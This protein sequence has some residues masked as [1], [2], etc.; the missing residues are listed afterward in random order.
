MER[1][2]GLL[3]QIK[4]FFLGLP[5][6]RRVTFAALTAGIL[7]GT[8][9]LAWWVQQPQYR[10]L[11][12]GLGAADA[13]A[14]IEYLK[15]EKIPYRVSDNGGNIEVAAGRLY[16]TRMALAGRGI[17][18]GGGVGFEIFDKQTL[19]MTDFVQR[20]NYQ[21]ALQGELARSI[22]ELDTVE[23][24]RVH[25]AM[26]ERSLF[27]A[28][29][30]RPSASVVLKLR[31]GRTL[32]PEQI[33]GVVHLVA[34]S[35]EGLRPNDVTVVDVNGQVLTRDQA[36]QDARS[37][38]KGLMTFQREMEQGYT[39][40]IESMLARVLGPGHALARVTV[41]LD[42][43]QVEK[44]E[45]S[46]DPDRVAVR[47]EKRSKETSAQGGSA[48]VAT[49]NIT[50]EPA[51][52]TSGP[53]SE[54]EDSNLNYEISRVTSRRIEQMG[55]VKKLSVA[56]LV[57]GTWTGEGEARTFVPRPQEEIDRYR[58]LIKRAVGFNEERGDQIEVAS[59]PF[60]AP[61]ALEPPEA[62]GMLAK[63]GEFSEVLWRL[64]GV[65]VALVIV[66]TVIRPFLLAMASRAPVAAVEMPYIPPPSARATV[67]TP[68]ADLPVP[69]GM[70]QMAQQNP[71]HT[72]EV[73]RQWLAQK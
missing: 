52:A 19:G 36:E 53:T 18:Q 45:E 32:A 62:P 9:A 73:I 38:G 61:A 20:L 41:A 2:N 51:A 30:R 47:N 57:D 1:L 70:L 40:S 29:E 56:V 23:S 43:A 16:E 42:L 39:E 21:R 8:G 49:A 35:V 65:V 22:A 66:L 69:A 63:V 54:R 67:A 26:P 71:E 55:A 4:Q 50:N 11:Y 64:A 24:A 46:F 7:I 59:A 14:V 5:P 17:P 12:S 60:Q 15:A 72:A 3:E 48:G 33:A 37:P 25:L 44:T 68:G 10:A 27:L 58:E 13:G 6:A 28:E 31:A 34:A